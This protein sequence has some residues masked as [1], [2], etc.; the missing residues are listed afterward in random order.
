MFRKERDFLFIGTFSLQN[1][2]FS[3]IHRSAA[4]SLTLTHT[5]KLIHSSSHTHSPATFGVT[6]LILSI[7]SMESAGVFGHITLL[8]RRSHSEERETE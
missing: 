2:Y 8:N 7:S 1:T 3:P 4:L 6:A 5:N